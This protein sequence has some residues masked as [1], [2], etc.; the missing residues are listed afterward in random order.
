MIKIWAHRGCSYSYPENTL[1]AFKAAC[2]LPVTGLE[3]ASYPKA[4]L[5]LQEGT[6]PLLECYRSYRTKLEPLVK[7]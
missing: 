5:Q 1:P 3:R 6:P 7:R 4:V 2:Q